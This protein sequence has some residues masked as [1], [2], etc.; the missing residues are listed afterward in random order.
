MLRYIIAFFVLGVSGAWANIV[1]EGSESCQALSLP[2]GVT[3]SMSAPAP[4]IAMLSAMRR[5]VRHRPA[6]RLLG[7]DHSA[8]TC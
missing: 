8:E 7:A 3:L 6:L 1:L 5:L 4:G 2:G